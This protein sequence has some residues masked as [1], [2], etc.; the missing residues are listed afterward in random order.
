[1]EYPDKNNVGDGSQ[2]GHNARDAA[3]R[4]GLPV[5]GLA[6]IYGDDPSVNVRE[7]RGQLSGMD[8]LLSSK[9][10]TFWIFQICG[11][12]GYSFLRTF[13]AITNGQDLFYF[14]WVI[15]AAAFV[16]LSMTTLLRQ[17]Y[18]LAREWPLQ[19]LLLFVVVIC[20]ACGLL[21]SM[22]ELYIAPMIVPGLPPFTGLEM[23]GNAM[24]ETTALFAWSALYF[25]YHYYQ[26]MR[27]Q[28]EQVLKATA[29]AHQAQLKML[30]Y[31]LNPHFLFNTLN[32]ISTLVLERAEAD[33][34]KML[35]KLSSFLRFTLVNQPTQRITLEQELY[36]LGL[37]LDIEN[38]RF[39]D[40]LKVDF[41]IEED[42]K[43]ALI[44]SLLL[45]P[46]IENAIKYAIA[47]SIE[48]GTISVAAHVDGGNL[49]IVLKDTGPGIEDLDNIVSQ[50]GS[51]VGIVNTKERLMQIYGPNHRISLQ[52]LQPEG[53]GIFIEIPC[54]REKRP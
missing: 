39:G 12:T 46:L 27:E 24:F 20:G 5:R 30:R 7:H 23:F 21:F 6:G 48:G 52:N 44:P 4:F 25:G 14:S 43:T 29:M 53:L 26:S 54:E 10:H 34:N 40:R 16:G 51:G 31:Q 9:E 49:A 32:A 13:Q 11:W 36:A 8:R 1:M 17:L 15:I 28:Q 2:G 3:T 22:I 47:P 33:A 50:S 41:D 35:T 42:A 37:Y 45:Q 38:V 19:W 18:R